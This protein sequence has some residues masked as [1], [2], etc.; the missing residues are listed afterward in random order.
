MIQLCDIDLEYVC[1]LKV[2]PEQQSENIGCRFITYKKV[3]DFYVQRFR[4]LLEQVP[5]RHPIPHLIL[6][7][8]VG[9]GG[10][11]ADGFAQFL[12]GH[13]AVLAD[14]FDLFAGGHWLVLFIVLL[15]IPALTVSAVGALS[16]FISIVPYTPACG[17]ANFNFFAKAIDIRI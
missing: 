9:A 12:L 16:C 14:A 3:F 10:T 11:E 1:V 4:N 6:G 7:D 13:L 17:K 8:T 2:K 15:I 5:L